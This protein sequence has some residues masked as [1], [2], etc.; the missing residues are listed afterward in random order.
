[1]S[2]FD[3]LPEDIAQQQIYWENSNRRRAWRMHQAGLTYK[4]IGERLGISGQRACEMAKR[5][6]DKKSPAERY[7]EHSTDIMK[8]AGLLHAYNYARLRNV[9]L[10][11]KWVHAEKDDD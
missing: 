1:M 5:F 4:Q 11:K 8:L 10:Y 7:L 9:L 3:I 2:W 6:N